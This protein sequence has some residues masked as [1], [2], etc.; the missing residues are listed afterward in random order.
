L[1]I[2][3]TFCRREGIMAAATRAGRGETA[4]EAKAEAERRDE[5][6]VQE[7][8]TREEEE[9]EE[10]EEIRVELGTLDIT[11]DDF[12]LGGGQHSRYGMRERWVE[13]ERDGLREM[14]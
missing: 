6:G 10:E 9:E 2:Y 14:G 12:S 5:E 8:V 1:S 7:R 13:R 3:F 11:S 4:A